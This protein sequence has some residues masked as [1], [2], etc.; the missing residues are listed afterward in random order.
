M[1]LIVQQAYSE[2]SL[3]AFDNESGNESVCMC[4]FVTTVSVC[5]C[6]FVCAD[7]EEGERERERYGK[8]R[9]KERGEKWPSV[10]GIQ[11]ETTDDHTATLRRRCRHSR[12]SPTSTSV[13]SSSK[14]ITAVHCTLAVEE[15]G[16]KEKSTS[17]QCQLPATTN[18]CIRE[19]CVCVCECAIL[20]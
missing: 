16:Q 3:T 4:V 8:E 11:Q 13:P 6:L 15:E 5:C 1:L 20:E 18:G 2:S 12:S 17:F 19:K 10:A 7:F 14:D 9:G